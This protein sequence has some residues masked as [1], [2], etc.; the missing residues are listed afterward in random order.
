M[1]VPTG[2]GERILITGG[3]GFVGSNLVLRLLSLG[4]KVAVLTRA[5]SSHVRLD[6]ISE[7]IEWCVA[8]LED[9]QAVRQAVETVRPVLVYHLASSSFNPPTTDALGHARINIIGTMHLL[10]ALRLIVPHARLVYTGS[11]AEY[12]EGRGLTENLVPAP[13]TVL[14]ATKAAAATLIQAYSRLYGVETVVLRL[15]TPYGPYERPGRLVPYTILS[16]LRNRAVE[17]SAGTQQRDFLY[18][19][20]LVD[21][22]LRAAEATVPKDALIN[23][24]SGE[25]RTVLEL[26]ETILRLMGNPVQAVPGARPARHDEIWELSGN[27]AAALE[28]LG[29]QPRTRLE[30]GL[31]KTI[32]WI[33]ENRALAERLT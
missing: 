14:G 32:T 2:L 13:R 30:D 27:N 28:L 8:D 33:E 24:C 31:S 23:I 6:R 5:N 20:D 18:V 17:L 19:D 7:E 26:V 10:E 25:S 21:A 12:G 15:F 11:A 1:Q 29:W 16:A 22:L 9:R 3:T 4:C